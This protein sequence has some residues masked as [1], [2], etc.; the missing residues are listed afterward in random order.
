MGGATAATHGLQNPG[1]NGLPL[2]PLRYKTMVETLG[3]MGV[4][5]RTMNQHRGGEPTCLN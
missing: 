5:Y 4:S 1:G 3:Q 2:P